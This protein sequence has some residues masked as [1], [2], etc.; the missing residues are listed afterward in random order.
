MEFI[1]REELREPR[2]YFTIMGLIASG[3]TRLNDISMGSGL[4][5]NVV[6]RYLS[7]MEDLGFLRRKVPVTKRNPERSRKGIY[8]I[9]DN[10]FRFWFRFVLPNLG[11]IEIGRGDDVLREFEENRNMYVSLEYEKICIEALWK[12][13]GRDQLGYIPVRIGRWWDR[14]DEIDLIALSDKDK[15]ITFGECKWTNRKMSHRDLTDL[16]RKAEI[17]DW[18]GNTADEDYILF[19][20]SGFTNRLRD[21]HPRNVRLVDLKDLDLI[22][23]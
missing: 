16:M 13:A 1:L 20:R 9:R 22:L 2:Q 17:I 11:R 6:S 21:D 8:R 14:N 5:R 7:I 10:Y 18:H 3:K 15:R 4:E 12:M 19:S 23:M